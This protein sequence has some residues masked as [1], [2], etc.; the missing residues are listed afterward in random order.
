MH[1]QFH[2]QNLL[3]T[4][5][6]EPLAGSKTEAADP[7]KVQWKRNGSSAAKKPQ[8]ASMLF[9]SIM[10]VVL[11]AQAAILLDGNHLLHSARLALLRVK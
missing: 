8:D 1:C 5:F 10:Q 9:T 11:R 6:S 3:Q 4:A 2:F 7:Q